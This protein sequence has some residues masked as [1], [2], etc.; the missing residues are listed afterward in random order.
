M[1]KASVG[2]GVAPG[3]W[4][5]VRGAWRV[6]VVALGLGLPGARSAAAQPPQTVVLVSL[7]GFHPDYLRRYRAPNLVALAARG[8]QARWLTPAFPSN[9]FPNHYTIVTGLLPAHH[10]IVDNHFVDPADGVRFRYSAGDARQARWWRGEPLWVTAEHQG[11]RA[12]SFFWPGSD[13][14]DPARRPSRYQLYDGRVPDPD[15]VDTV[16]AWLDLPVAERPRFITLYFSDV[17]HFGHQDGPG[18]PEVAGAVAL[19]DSMIG[20][21]MEGIARRRLDNVVNVVVVSD[22]GMAATSRD[23][24]IV[25]D[26]FLDR[27]RVNAISLG[28]TI[29]LRPATR[30]GLP[31]DSI[32][33]TLAGV[34]HLFVY[35]RAATPERWRYRDNPRVSDVV[36]VAEAGWLLSTRAALASGRWAS[37]GSHGF[38]NADSTMRALFIAAGP[39]FRR[40][41]VVEPFQNLH[42]YEL[43]CRVLGLRPA[44]NDG[45]LDSVRTL[46]R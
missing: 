24:V 2:G 23:R 21:L 31:A 29:Q 14:D 46:L 35:P 30:N 44:P 5:V 15:R 32:A 16:L 7:D 10:G 36:G 22:H 12:A 45:S 1:R 33:S 28:S 18:S 19:V 3:A 11:V 39:A 41:V 26:D 25:L 40:G 37:G 13:L 4:C 9:T 8:V 34:P 17:D 42:V 20:R 38:D 6:A 27:E 43:V